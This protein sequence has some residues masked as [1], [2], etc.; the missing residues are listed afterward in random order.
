MKSNEKEI[1][2]KIDALLDKL[3]QEDMIKEENMIKIEN[4]IMTIQQEENKVTNVINI[5]SK[6]DDT[7]KINVDIINQEKN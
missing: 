3:P 2:D 4:E 5:V 6:K 1:I 7:I